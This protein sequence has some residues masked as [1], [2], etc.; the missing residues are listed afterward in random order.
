LGNSGP[1]TD[2]VVDERWLIIFDNLDSED[3]KELLDEFKPNE[4]NAAGSVLFTSRDRRLISQYG[5]RQVPDLDESSAAELLLSLTKQDESEKSYQFTEERR[6]AGEVARQLGCYPLALITAANVIVNSQC[7]LSEFLEAFSLREMVEESEAVQFATNIEGRYS[8]SL[9]TVWDMNFKHLE[10][11]ERGLLNLLAFLDADGIPS[12][13]LFEGCTKTQK[14]ELAFLGSRLKLIQCRK[15][16]LQSSLVEQNAESGELGMH[17]M[18]RLICHIKMSPQERQESFT[19]AVYMVH[20]AWP[21]AERHFRHR[22]ELWEDQRA[23]LPHVQSL[24]DY[25]VSSREKDSRY[26]PLEADLDFA[27]MLYQASWYEVLPSPPNTSPPHS[28]SNDL[29]QVSV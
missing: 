14:P 29:T 2:T 19:R 24:C 25:Y 22:P 15:K 9:S 3:N 4:Q 26:E 12:R 28:N 23:Y 13:L 20:S 1:S 11:N 27:D 5:G 16:M 17:R 7:L 18:V 21:V 10:G 6:A 8:H